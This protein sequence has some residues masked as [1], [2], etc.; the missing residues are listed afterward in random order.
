MNKI[1]TIEPGAFNLLEGLEYL[2]LRWNDLKQLPL[3]AL[4]VPSPRWQLRIRN[5]ELPTL[6][7][8][9]Q[10]ILLLSYHLLNGT[11][12]FYHGLE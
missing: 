11:C 9:F 3:G 7:G 10:G 2:D 5:N 8:A 6:E 12:Y 1:E 4:T